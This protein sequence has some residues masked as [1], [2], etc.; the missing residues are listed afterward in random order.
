M[1]TGCGLPK[2]PE[3][4]WEG[5]SPGQCGSQPLGHTLLSKSLGFGGLYGKAPALSVLFWRRR[6][7]GVDPVPGDS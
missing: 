7:G 6:H 3:W 5:L 2:L 4:L 1:G